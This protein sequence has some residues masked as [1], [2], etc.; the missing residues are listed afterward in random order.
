MSDAA[1][2]WAIVT[3]TYH[4]DYE[5]FKLMCESMDHFVKGQWHHYVVVTKADY[6]MFAPFNGPRRT[7]IENTKILPPWLRYIGKLG[8]VRS[9][10]FWFSWRTGPIFGWH[11]QQIVKLSMASFVKEDKLLLVDSDLFFVRPFNLDKIIKN[12]IIP[13]WRSSDDYQTRKTAPPPYID[14]AKKI[15]GI[16]LNTPSHDHAN[17]IVV[18]DRQTAIDLCDY[19]AKRHKKHWIAALSGFQAISE[20]SFYGLYVEHIAP[21]KNRFKNV[22]YFFTKTTG[23]DIQM[24]ETD[25]EKFVSTLDDDNVAFGFQS[26]ARYDNNKLR[27]IYN[28]F[29]SAKNQKQ[30]TFS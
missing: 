4:L 16:D 19:I 23:G 27:S 14:H 1:Q 17:N 5:Q 3:P 15:L 10:S 18:W 6:K 28:N 24:S 30:S 13:L 25:F 22:S 2:K 11:I 9:G 7:V 21:D 8:R 20:G 26:S 29:L 12:A